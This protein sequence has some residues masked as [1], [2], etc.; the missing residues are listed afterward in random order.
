MN[1]FTDLPAEEIE[2][3]RLA[4]V[5][6]MKKLS[7]DEFGRWYQEKCDRFYWS[8]GR[9]CAGCDYWSSEGGWTGECLAAPP[10]SGAQVLKSMGI[11]WCT[12]TPPPGQPYTSHDHVCGAFKDD[13]DWTT[14]DEEYRRRIGA[15]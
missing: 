2:R 7:G 1:R 14:L 12:Y 8:N 11:E 13:F 3:R 5:E 15:P 6:E 4:S 9:C 10:V